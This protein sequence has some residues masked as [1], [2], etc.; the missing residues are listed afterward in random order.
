MS[1]RLKLSPWKSAADFNKGSILG[2]TPSTAPQEVYSRPLINPDHN[3]QSTNNGEQ[4]QQTQEYPPDSIQIVNQVNEPPYLALAAITAFF[5]VPVVIGE[6]FAYYINRKRFDRSES[7]AINRFGKMAEILDSAAHCQD[8][9]DGD[10][11]KRE[12]FTQTLQKCNEFKKLLEKHPFS[13]L[14]LSDE[15]FKQLTEVEFNN[16]HDIRIWFTKSPM[17]ILLKQHTSLDEERRTLIQR[18]ERR[19]GNRAARGVPPTPTTTTIKPGSNQIFGSLAFAG[20]FIISSL[21]KNPTSLA[22]ATTLGTTAIATTTTA[23]T[24]AKQGHKIFKNIRNNGQQNSTQSATGP[25]GENQRGSNRSSRRSSR[26][27]I[28]EINGQQALNT[29]LL[30]QITTMSKQISALT[31]TQNEPRQTSEESISTS[32]LPAQPKQLSGIHLGNNYASGNSSSSG[33]GN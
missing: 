33:R 10:P 21:A 26:S 30:E 2:P 18:P 4:P 25:I 1:T 32:R 8:P 28:S 13:L 15:Q 19:L 9:L 6:K 22:A 29:E 20:A 16:T 27:G 14:E 7:K 11:T 31:A 17:Q 3:S 24:L 12:I 5:K 23:T